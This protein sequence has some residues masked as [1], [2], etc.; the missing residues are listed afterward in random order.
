[1]DHERKLFFSA[2]IGGMI[3]GLILG[4]WIGLLI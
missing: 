1:M 2:W 3:I 4:F